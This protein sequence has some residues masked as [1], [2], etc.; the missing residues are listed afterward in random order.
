MLRVNRFYFTVVYLLLLFYGTK[1]S[2]IS[3]GIM[4]I[5]AIDKT[6]KNPIIKIFSNT[7]KNPV[8]VFSRN[9]NNMKRIAYG[10]KK[11]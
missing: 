4:A 10:L 5:K 11:K 6:I 8:G 3:Y 7:I 1:Q 9:K 2:R